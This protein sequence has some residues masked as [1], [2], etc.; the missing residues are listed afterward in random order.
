MIGF[1]WR[2]TEEGPIIV[3]SRNLKEHG[4]FSIYIFQLTRLFETW[5]SSIRI[6]EE[7]QFSRLDGIAQCKCTLIG[8]CDWLA[9]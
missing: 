6:N 1:D 2:I 8:L 9:K 5:H 7:L 3:S 4:P